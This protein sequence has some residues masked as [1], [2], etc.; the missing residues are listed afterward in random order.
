MKTFGRL[1]TPNTLYTNGYSI[2]RTA[3][4]W[5]FTTRIHFVFPFAVEIP[6]NTAC[7]PVATRTHNIRTMCPLSRHHIIITLLSFYFNTPAGCTR[8]TLLLRKPKNSFCVS[9]FRFFIA[10]V[11]APH[12]TGCPARIS[13]TKQLLFRATFLTFFFF[14]R[15]NVLTFAVQLKYVSILHT[16]NK[17]TR[18]F[19]GLQKKSFCQHDFIKMSGKKRVIKFLVVHFLW[20]FWN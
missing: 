16:Q 17:K 15:K 13:Q 4:I 10:I 14:F 5:S 2:H 11:Y 3:T 12:Q 9:G 8:T 7:F 19:S 18:F 20:F 1:F 6:V